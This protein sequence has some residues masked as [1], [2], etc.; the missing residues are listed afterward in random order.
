MSRETTFDRDLHAVRNRTELM[1]IF[2]ELRPKGWRSRHW[3]G[4]AQLLQ[5]LPVIGGAAHSGMQAETIDIG[6][7][8]L[9]ESFSVRMAPCSVSTFWPLRG[10][11]AMW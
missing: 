9:R 2:T 5:R 4:A 6:A 8:P 3:P 10:P 7:Q 11:K 1:L